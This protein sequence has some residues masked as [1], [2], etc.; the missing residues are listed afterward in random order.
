MWMLGF[1][2]HFTLGGFI[3]M[4]LALAIISVLIRIVAGTVL[5]DTLGAFMTP[6]TIVATR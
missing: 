3:Q 2:L 4:L 1:V 6:P 5:H